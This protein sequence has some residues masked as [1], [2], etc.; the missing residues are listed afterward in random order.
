MLLSVASGSGVF[1]HVPQLISKP[2]KAATLLSGQHYTMQCVFSGR[3]VGRRFSSGF[4]FGFDLTRRL[5]GH[6]EN[7]STNFDDW[8]NCRDYERERRFGMTRFD[9]LCSATNA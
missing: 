2:V 8:W 9:P 7:W 5:T 4:G 6:V 3:S 1:H